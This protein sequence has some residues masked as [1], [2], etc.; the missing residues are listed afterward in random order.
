MSLGEFE[1]N[2]FVLKCFPAVYTGLFQMEKLLCSS[3]SCPAEGSRVYHRLCLG[4]RPI[5]HLL[6]RP[7]CAVF[8]VSSAP[9]RVDKAV[10]AASHVFNFGTEDLNARSNY[11]T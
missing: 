7:H 9:S 4:P 1:T 10:L 2:F 6:T 11:S 5:H 3:E 8:R